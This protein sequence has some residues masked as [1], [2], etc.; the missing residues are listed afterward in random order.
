MRGSEAVVG[1]KSKTTKDGREENRGFVERQ[2]GKLKSDAKPVTKTPA[3]ERLLGILDLKKGVPLAP[4]SL[5]ISWILHVRLSSILNSKFF[6][7][8]SVEN[9]GKNGQN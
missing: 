8:I 3:V 6:S 4:P 7:K 5:L 1:K 9:Y 2:L